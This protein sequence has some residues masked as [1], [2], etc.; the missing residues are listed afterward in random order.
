MNYQFLGPSIDPSIPTID[1]HESRSV[2]EA[3]DQLERSLFLF[4]KRNERYC[5]V[6]HGIGE[7]V[8]ANAV[9]ELLEK[10]P[11]V[12]EWQEEE[13]GGSCIVIL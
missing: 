3:I 1:L 12:G 13:S 11:L 7:G 2:S 8:L 5:R 10:H 6:I 9:H 4:T